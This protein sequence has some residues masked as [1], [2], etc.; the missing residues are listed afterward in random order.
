M[1]TYQQVFEPKTLSNLNSQ[2]V[3]TEEDIQQNV[4][5]GQ[6]MH[7]DDLMYHQQ[8]EHNYPEKGKNISS[9]KSKDSPKKRK[10]P[11]IRTNKKRHVCCSNCAVQESPLWRKGAEGKVLCNKCG[12]Y[13]SR[14]GENR[15]TNL[16]RINRKKSVSPKRKS[17]PVE[18]A[19]QEDSPPK[20]RKRSTKHG[21][22]LRDRPA[23]SRKLFE[24]ELEMKQ[25]I[26]LEMKDEVN[27][28]TTQ[29]GSKEVMF[30]PSTYQKQISQQQQ[31]YPIC[32]NQYQYIDYSGMTQIPQVYQSMN[33]QMENQYIMITEGEEELKNRIVK[34][35]QYMTPSVDLSV[36]NQIPLQQPIVQDCRM[37]YPM[38]INS[39]SNYQV[40]SYFNDYRCLPQ[41]EDKLGYVDLFG[42]NFEHSNIVDINGLFDG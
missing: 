24:D 31:Q 4:E 33:H 16:E 23:S 9:P 15:P 26:S 14:H 38:Q 5:I 21:M 36:Q 19:P 6:T 22:T 37:T 39:F 20:R 2:F 13:W 17:S 3:K 25:E 18:L 42:D 41:N 34:S 1:M 11:S 10:K 32:R 35:Q 27:I 30:Q 28:Q 12:L 8:L 7:H 40:N 29:D